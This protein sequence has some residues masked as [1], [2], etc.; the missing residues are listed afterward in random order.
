MTT[1][2]APTP[3][4]EVDTAA[5][6]AFLGQVASDAATAFHAAT[7]VLGDKLGLYKALAEDGPATPAELAKRT[8]CDARYL[9]E[10]GN[11]QV[12]AGYCGYEPETG[13]LSLDPAQAIVLADETSPAFGAGLLSLAAVLFK[14]EERMNRAA[15]RTGDG[16]PWHD[17]HDDLFHGTERLF[18]PGYVTNLVESWIPA[19]DGV[20]E[21]LTTGAKV[22]DIGC[23]HGASTIVLAQAFPNSAVVGFDYHEAS[24]EVA[25]QRAKEAGID[26][27]V[28]FEVASAADFPGRDFDLACVF[29][30]LHDMG[31]PVGAATHIRSALTP[32]GT[33]LIVEPMSGESV[34]ENCNPIGKLFYSAG[35]FVCVPHAK[36]QG[37]AQQLGPQVPESTWRSLLAEAGFER[38]RRAAETPFNRVFEARP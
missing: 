30:A 6:E 23:G 7:V 25:R 20:V 11:A 13:R 10:W 33:F 29:D 24:I 36:A 17:H 38:F 31:D 16:V 9:E 18:K 34:L 15:V 5:V 1:T 27:R 12:A 3:I 14:D 21:K 19:L 8:G 37:G 2:E 32:D 26:D 28:S 4:D 35:L 22:A